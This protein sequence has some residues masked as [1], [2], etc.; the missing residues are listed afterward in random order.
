MEKK[1]K[2]QVIKLTDANYVRTLENSIQFGTPGNESFRSQSMQSN[3]MFE[4]QFHHIACIERDF[5]TFQHKLNKRNSRSDN[6][7]FGVTSIKRF[8]KG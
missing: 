4:N 3:F 7:L 8:K 2:L 5:I 1:N 6:V